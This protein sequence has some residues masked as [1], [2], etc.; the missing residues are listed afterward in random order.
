MICERMLN[1]LVS[2]TRCNTCDIDKGSNLFSSMMQDQVEKVCAIARPA[3]QIPN[4]R[5]AAASLPHFQQNLYIGLLHLGAS[6]CQ[7]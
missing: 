1:V 3:P 2:D 6:L 7:A 5:G 4:A